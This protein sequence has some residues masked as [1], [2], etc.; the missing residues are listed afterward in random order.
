MSI[1]VQRQ[2]LAEIKEEIDNIDRIINKDGDT[3]KD[4]LMYDLYKLLCE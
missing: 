1:E 3:I 2:M 4:S